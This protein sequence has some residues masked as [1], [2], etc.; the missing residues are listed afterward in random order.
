MFWQNGGISLQHDTFSETSC[1]AL[2]CDGSSGH[3][4]RVPDP[5][6]FF[7]KY[8]GDL[9]RE[10]GGTGPMQAP[11]SL[12]INDFFYRVYGG[13]VTDRIRLL[14]AL[15]DSYKAVY[16]KAE[17][18]DEFIF[19]GEVILADFGDVDKFLVDPD[20]LFS[21]IADLRAMQ[22]DFSYLSPEQQA[23]L[24]A[25]LSH[26]RTGGEYKE[27]FRRIW[28][29]L[30]PR[31]SRKVLL[32]FYGPSV[33]WIEGSVNLHTF[34]LSNSQTFE[35]SFAAAALAFSAAICAR[36]VALARRQCWVMER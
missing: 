19:W 14:L 32:T 27:A 17:P 7:R 25:F 2:S 1:I 31:G 30:L 26:F 18:L 22:D 13:E 5:A 15:Y 12:T 35:P 28:D 24:K 34:K 4:L 29:I 20:R 9:L 8:L 11:M 6:V 21:N 3:L 36:M 23:A 10:G 33:V 16:P